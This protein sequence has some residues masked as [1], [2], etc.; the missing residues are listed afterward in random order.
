MKLFVATNWDKAL[1][2]RL[3][4]LPVVTLYGQLATDVLGGGRPSFQLPEVSQ[5]Q[6]KEYIDLTHAFGMKFN[7]LL[8]PQCMGNMEYNRNFHHAMVEHIQWIVDIGADSVTVT[9]PLLLELIKKQFPKLRTA[10]SVYA[11]VDTVQRAQYWESLGAD[12]ITLPEHV[13]RNFRLIE[14]IRKAVTC[15]LQALANITCLYGC[16]YWPYHSNSVSHASRAGDPSEGF[17]IDYCVLSCYRV[18]AREPA[19]FIKSRWIR[20]EDVAR[21]ESL[22]V[23]HFKIAERFMTTDTLVKIAAAY[24]SRRYDGNLMDLLNIRSRSDSYLPMQL[25]KLL[26]PEFANVEKLA[27]VDDLLPSVRP[28]IDN[29]ALDGFLDF[30]EKNDCD[31]IDCRTC[32][33]CQRLS[34]KVLTPN[35][36]APE[37]WMGLHEKIEDLTTSRIFG[38]ADEGDGRQLVWEEAVQQEFQEGL[39]SIPLMFRGVA[40]KVLSSKAEAFARKRDSRTVERGDVVRALLTAAP[41]SFRPKVLENLRRMNIDPAPYLAELAAQNQ[42]R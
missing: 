6:A 30:Y 12:M 39:S 2:E 4:G 7:Y 26:K 28:Y 9:I 38:D 14:R 13:N 5:K 10:I 33:Y 37:A 15:D 27:N 8:N 32:G 20:P 41:E 42:D 16:P 1:P 3:A 21:Y 25:E 18:F 31:E 29:R 17:Y 22:G 34:Q 35:P 40:K 11:H 23:D 36:E 19:E 24:A